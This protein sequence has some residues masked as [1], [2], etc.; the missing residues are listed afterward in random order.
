[1]FPLVGTPW[2]MDTVT[3]S[4]T[5]LVCLLV[6]LTSATSQNY[7]KKKKDLFPSPRIPPTESYFLMTHDAGR[8]KVSDADIIKSVG[9]H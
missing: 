3:H 8:R 9:R 4:P 2:I 1:M 5:S 7:L 6:P